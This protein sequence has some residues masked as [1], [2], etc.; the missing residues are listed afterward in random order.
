[1][2]TDPAEHPIHKVPDTFP[3]PPGDLPPSTEPL[4][5]PPQPQLPQLSASDPYE[6]E[7][8]DENGD[9]V[10]QPPRM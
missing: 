5:V 6:G 7:Q 8:E 1:M 10:G 2:A 4:T 9:P 3:L